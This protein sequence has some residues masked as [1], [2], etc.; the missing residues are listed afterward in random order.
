[1]INPNPRYLIFRKPTE[2]DNSSIVFP[3]SA[4]SM[5]FELEKKDLDFI[6]GDNQVCFKTKF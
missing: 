4:I 5:F 1:M 2:N 3:F 6:K